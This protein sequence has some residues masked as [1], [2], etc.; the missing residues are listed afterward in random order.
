MG[1]SRTLARLW[2]PQFVAK[3][4]ISVAEKRFCTY[5]TDALGFL[6]NCYIRQVLDVFHNDPLR[7]PSKRYGA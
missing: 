4:F 5:V 3:T 7:V 6:N 2:T 1:I